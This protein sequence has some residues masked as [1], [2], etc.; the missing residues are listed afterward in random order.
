MARGAADHGVAESDVTEQ[1]PHT[2]PASHPLFVGL[3][4]FDLSPGRENPRNLAREV[5]GPEASIRINQ[6]VW[7]RSLHRNGSSPTDYPT[8]SDSGEHPQGPSSS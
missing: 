1:L 3:Y 2:S 6:G 8:L 4:T 7:R 5:T